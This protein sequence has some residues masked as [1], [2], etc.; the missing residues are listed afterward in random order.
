MFLFSIPALFFVHLSIF[1]RTDC[2]ARH[3]YRSVKIGIFL[4]TATQICM[5]SWLNTHSQC[6]PVSDERHVFMFFNELF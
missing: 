6:V 4:L 1:K 2:G 5:G 3:Q